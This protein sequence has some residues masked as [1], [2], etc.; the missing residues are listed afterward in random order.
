MMQQQR[1]QNSLSPA[2]AF[3]G[4]VG[5]PPQKRMKAVEGFLLVL[6]VSTALRINNEGWRNAQM[7]WQVV[8]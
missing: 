8:L 5:K 6:L 2:R 1:N 7:E 3:E 4:A